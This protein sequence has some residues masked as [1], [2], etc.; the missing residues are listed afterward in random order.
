MTPRLIP[1]RHCARDSRESRR[2]P[3][4]IKAPRPPA[5]FSVA[6]H[7]PARPTSPRSW[8]TE[9][10][11]DDR[12]RSGP[13][14]VARWQ[15]P[16][17]AVAWARIRPGRTLAV[18]PRPIIQRV[19]ISRHNEAACAGSNP[20]LERIAKMFHLKCAVGRTRTRSVRSARI[21]P[22]RSSSSSATLRSCSGRIQTGASRCGSSI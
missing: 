16:A 17:R 18:L 4:L 5:P 2:A 19:G 14:K 9:G 13:R 12:P 11:G 21:S 6:S 8:W 3:K 15:C 10:T 20:A 7:R 1:C 22:R